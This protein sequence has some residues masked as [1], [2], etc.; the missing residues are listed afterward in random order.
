L[1]SLM[2]PASFGSE[3]LRDTNRRLGLWL[4]GMITASGELSATPD[5]IGALLNELLRVGS[6][7]RSRPLPAAG[8]DPQWDA[9]L[10]VYRRH[11][12][13]LRA[14]LPSI[15]TRLLA[16]RARIEAQRARICAAC[17][18]ASASRQTL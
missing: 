18:W 14:L 16:E 3:T 17:E 1:E 12:E 15:H 11:L 8:C 5:N 7:L 10:S 4:D 13:R 9:E 6:E 2:T